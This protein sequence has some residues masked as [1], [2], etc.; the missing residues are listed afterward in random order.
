LRRLAVL[1]NGLL[2]V[3]AA[4]TLRG[5]ESLLYENELKA[6]DKR[7]IPRGKR[8]ETVEHPADSA[9]NKAFSA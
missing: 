8:L 9:Q 5:M 4:C 1:S 3:E 6:R 2:P 7:P